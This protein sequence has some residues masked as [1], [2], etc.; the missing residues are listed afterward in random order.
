MWNINDDFKR[1]LVKGHTVVCK[2]VLLDTDFNEVE[3]DTIFSKQ[4]TNEITNFISDGN[5][6]VDTTR[7]TRRTAELT[8]LNPTAE[9]TPSTGNFKS[10]GP[11]TGKIYVNRIIRIYRG[12]VVSGSPVYI[13]A[14]TFMVDNCEVQVQQNA[15]LVVLTL[16][17]L[18]KK[19]TKSNFTKDEFYPKGTLYN[20]IM[21]Q[22]LWDAGVFDPLNLNSKIVP[23]LDRLTDRDPDER[24]TSSDISFSQ[25]DSR[26]DKL[27]ELLPSWGIDA[28]FDPMG[29]F[30]SQDRKDPK[31][32]DV[33]WKFYSSI[34][35]DGMMVSLTRSFNDDN[36]YNHV[37]VVGSGNP[38]KTVRVEKRETDPRSKISI[39]R[40]GDRVMI[41]DSQTISTDKEA[42]K[43]LNKAWKNR[44]QLSEAI[45]LEAICNPA[46]EGDDVIKVTEAT[47]AKIDD[48]Y[49]I[50]RFSIPLVTA[51]QVIQCTNILHQEDV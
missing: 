4:Q 22:L 40:I 3:D 27:K 39:D 43:A 17:D 13:P 20:A 36:L 42:K 6:D 35:G 50:V 44:F 34:K 11:W 8:L 31:D 14:G 18:W 33:V 15:S 19:L 25:G 29:R 49:R 32:K 2:V 38:K 12:I 47:Y 21:E 51:R 24:V 30:V 48:T 37:V 23:N 46:L 16:S 41:I 10:E 26:G 1:T 28:Y 45:E 7:G 5:I 9:F